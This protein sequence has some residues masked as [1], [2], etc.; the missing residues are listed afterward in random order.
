MS[1]QTMTKTKETTSDQEG[2]R[3][4]IDCRQNLELL[5]ETILTLSLISDKDK[6][7]PGTFDPEA[8]QGLITILFT[9]FKKFHN[10]LEESLENLNINT[11]DL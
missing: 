5:Q 6:S 7:A 1:N 8:Y 3:L 4:S 2:R 10:S 9:S 11:D